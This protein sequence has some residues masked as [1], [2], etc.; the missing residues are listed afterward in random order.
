MAGLSNYAENKIISMF[1][2]GDTF[3]T[4]SGGSY[5]S[6]HA[7][8]PNDGA[9]A[10]EISAGAFSYT[11]KNLTTSQWS[12]PSGGTTSNTV[13]V[14]WTNLPSA[15]LTHI[16]IWDASSSGNLLFSGPIQGGTKVVSNGDTYT[17]Q[18]GTL[19]VNVD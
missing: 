10:T 2:R 14:Q 3:T 16:G 9:S 19:V 13:Q 4:L 1:L 6:L 7:G 17:I 15:N 12:A 18:I 8:D 5:V 11:R